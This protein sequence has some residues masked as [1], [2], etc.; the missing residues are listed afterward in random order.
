MTAAQHTRLCHDPPSICGR[1]AGCTLLYLYFPPIREARAK[2]IIMF[3]KGSKRLYCCIAQ[4]RL[5]GMAELA[6]KPDTLAKEQA[7]QG[8]C[9]PAPTA[10]D[11]RKAVEMRHVHGTR[12]KQRQRANRRRAVPVGALQL[13][14]YHGNCP[15]LRT[16]LCW[17]DRIGSSTSTTSGGT[18]RNARYHTPAAHE[19]GTTRLLRTNIDNNTRSTYTHRASRQI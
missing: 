18:S 7:D 6:E 8:P 2:V 19:A 13:D 16:L 17:S 14:Y 15:Q 12:R 5:R 10:S 4:L 1:P 11:G 9:E 3:A